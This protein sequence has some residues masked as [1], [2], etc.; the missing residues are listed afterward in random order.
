MNS[1]FQRLR[2]GYVP[3]SRELNAP[4]DRRRFVRWAES[5]GVPFTIADPGQDY[6]VVVLSELADI[7]VWA[8]YRKGRIVYDLIDSYLAIPRSDWKG[9]LRGLAKFVSRQSRYLQTDYWNAV[10]K[11]CA[12]ADAVVCTTLEQAQAITAFCINTHVILDIHG[13]VARQF[14]QNYDAHQPFKLVWE[15]LPQNVQAFKIVAGVLNKLAHEY[16]LQLNLV[17]DPNYFRYLG[18][19]GRGNVEREARKL[20]GAVRLHPWNEATCASIICDCDLGMVPL[21]LD[22]AF[23]AGK[24][25]NKLLLFWR[26]G[27]PVITSA[28]PA[29]S[30]AMATAGLDMDCNSAEEWERVLRYYIE[31]K[32][33]RRQ[34]GEKGRQRA[35]VNYGEQE[36]LRRWDRVFESVIK[37]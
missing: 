37:A 16:P 27:M 6:D 1:V 18:R 14:K 26:L 20:F 2:V 35:E 3:Y 31:H 33:A 15:G 12:R 22:D 25:E 5:R 19:F 17:T 29:Y 4:G 23:A 8:E 32:G 28:S 24:P 9:R 13:M 7:S 30:R 11:M 36:M 10:Q 21:D 34:A